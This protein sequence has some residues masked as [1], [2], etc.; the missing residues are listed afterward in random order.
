MCATRPCSPRRRGFSTLV[1][2]IPSEG[3]SMEIG[4][5]VEVHTRFNN[6]WVTGFEIAA[7]VGSGYRLSRTSDGTVLP[8]V[9]SE[10][11]LRLEPPD[12]S[13]HAIGI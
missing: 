5:R 13:A 8:S 9:T 11:D 3:V 4:D 6:T 12:K 2:S 10:S 7:V 1:A